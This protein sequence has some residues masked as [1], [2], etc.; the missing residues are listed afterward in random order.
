MYTITRLY[1]FL[2]HILVVL[3]SKEWNGDSKLIAV[4]K[5]SNSSEGRMF[6]SCVCW[7][8]CW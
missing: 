2:G 1:R 7:V 6:V 5:G 3:R 4:I 8:L